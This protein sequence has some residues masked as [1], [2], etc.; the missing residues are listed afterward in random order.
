VRNALWGALALALAAPSVAA[1]QPAFRG[2]FDAWEAA[3]PMSGPLARPPLD[4]LA[5]RGWDER[6]GA[7][8]LLVGRGPAD[9]VARSDRARAWAHLARLAPHFGVGGPALQATALTRTRALPGGGL[10]AIFEQRVDG[11]PVFQS[12]LSLLIDARGALVAAGG[13]LS[14][15]LTRG[16]WRSDA[17]RATQRAL[18][19]HFG[20]SRHRGSEPALTAAQGRPDGWSRFRLAASARGFHMDRDARARR[21]LY[22]LPTH[23]APAHHV[24]LWVPD[25]RGGILV[26]YVIGA[27]DGAVLMRRELT[28]WDD[29]TYRVF[30]DEGAPFTPVDS[31]FGDTTPDRAGRP[32]DGPLPA[33]VGQGMITVEAFNGPRDPWL[34]SGAVWTRGN[35]VDAYADLVAPDGFDDG[36]VRAVTTSA[37]VFDHPFDGSRPPDAGV[38]QQQAAVTHL[39]FVNNWLHDWFYDV[40]FDEAAG[41]AQTDNLGRGG[42]AGDV[43]RAEALDHSGR[44]NANMSTPS[45]GESPRM[46]MFLWD[47]FEEAAV[48]A[49]GASYDVGVARFGPTDFDV[50]APTT[51]VDDG[52]GT[53]SDGCESLAADL[54]GRIAVI[55]R[56]GCS[57]LI[58]VQNA[59]AAGALAVIVVNDRGT[60][61]TNMSTST[62]GTAGIGAL[63]VSQAD[64]AGLRGGA[65]ARVH[66]TVGPDAA[67]SL[68][69]QVVT[70]E[71][72][73]YLHRRLVDFGSVQGRAE[74]EGWGDFLSVMM[75][76]RPG[77]DLRGAFPT[78]SYSNHGDEP[79]YY[80]TRRVPYS[81]DR[82]FDALSFRHIS[83]GEAL[84]DTHPVGPGPSD[85]SEVHNAGEIW[86]TMMFDALVA[87][88]E[89]SRA[90]GAPYDF[91]GG[92][93]RMAGYIVVGMQLAPRNPTFT[94]QRDALV[95]AALATD[96]EDARLIAQAFAGRGAGT[97]AISPS[98][99]STDLTGVVEHGEVALLPVIVSFTVDTDGPGLA[100]DPDG[101]LDVGEDGWARIEV[102][103]DGVV[104]MRGASLAMG[105][106]D[107]AVELPGGLIVPIG[108]LAPGASQVIDVPVR[109]NEGAGLPVTL[110]ATV[111]GDALCDDVEAE[112]R[113]ALDRDPVPA[114][115]ETFELGPTWVTEVS[116]D[117]ASGGVWSVG[118]SRLGGPGHAL[119]GLDSGSITDTAVELPEVTASATDPLVLSF[120]HRYELEAEPGTWWDGGVIEL[121]TDGGAT[122]S[123]VSDWV[124]PG[125]DGELTDRADNPLAFREAYS[126]QN[127]SHPD[128]DAV[129]L[130]FGTALAGQTVRFRFRIGTD[131]AT[132]A[133]GWEIDDLQ[134]DG[135][136]PP[137]FLGYGPDEADCADAPTADA[138]PDREVE[139]GAEVRLDGSGSR[140]PGGDALTFAWATVGAT[141]GATIEL[142]DPT[143]DAPTFTAPSVDAPLELTLRLRVSD[144][145]ASDTDDVVITV[146]PPPEPMH[147]DAGRPRPD[148]ASGL[149]PDGGVSADGGPT[150]M[151]EG[152]CGCRA[153]GGGAPS[154]GWLALALGLTA[155]RRL[156]SRRRRARRRRARAPAG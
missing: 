55:D 126:G 16:R 14:P 153:G 32:V 94:E 97:C 52:V 68:D 51:V 104:P 91:D 43:L 122:W 100:C 134:V 27:E 89:R 22:P 67:S 95:A 49:A 53:G 155:S 108:E 46:Q 145:S 96:A 28:D 8:T 42:E 12:R 11:V 105:A 150:E 84:P 25:P 85:N 63:M 140:D 45:D 138:G 77:D 143:S 9:P 76:L 7:A 90:A 59:E 119:R 57:F 124:A 47:G 41:N 50:T 81:V 144:G 44:N 66:R 154:L 19:D 71:W 37:N 82:A 136:E 98:R 152:G 139:S 86:A 6:R 10:L 117:G 106:D 110:R 156:R 80:G 113:V 83:D 103:N 33:F 120:L 149:S 135:A 17:R 99:G 65:T 115:R 129:S 39:F 109:V 137:P 123:D 93:R 30:A 79:V 26:D 72:G 40:G 1:A 29:Y 56:G 151:A 111:T 146:N 31:P 121:S 48:E 74:S 61:T 130:D 62:G 78:A 128:A 3:A 88:L 147:E 114:R 116:L 69:S 58:K 148:D 64:G 125:Y 15:T 60:G 102:R 38:G 132:G 5:V 75:G 92:L 24:E 23:L 112:R 141:V 70:H 54:S 21:V 73:H 35:N 18:A 101:L 131:Q 34:A 36:D 2:A 127:P 13:R 142:D 20:A 107:A 87:L 133:T 4:G 118:P